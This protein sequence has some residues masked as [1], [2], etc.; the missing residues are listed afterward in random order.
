MRT[1]LLFLFF[2]LLI[3]HVVAGG[4]KCEPITIPLCKNIGYNMTSYP[5]TRGHETQEEAGLEV[6]QFYPLVEVGCYTHLR[7]MLCGLYAP[8]CQEN[9]ELEILP[10]QEVCKEA[11]RKCSP[12]METHGFKWPETLNCDRLPRFADQQTTGTLCAAPPDATRAGAS[13]AVDEDAFRTGGGE[14]EERNRCDCQCA[15][16]FRLISAESAATA[17]F[18]VQNVSNCAYTCDGLLVAPKA[19]DRAFVRQWTLVFA[20]ICFGLSFFTVLTFAIDLKRFPYPERPI[21]Y[22]A[23]CQSMFALGY[24]L[25][26]LVDGE[27][28]GCES[29][30][31][32]QANHPVANSA[33]L[34]CMAVFTLTYYFSMAG[35]AFWVVLTVSFLLA[36]VPH[37]SSEWI[38]R[39]SRWFHLGAW[40][41]PAVQVAL[42]HYFGAV[43]GD[44]LTGICSV[45]NTN[46]NWLLLFVILPLAL[47]F[48]VGLLCLFTGFRNLCGIRADLKKTHP[49]MDKTSKLTQLM[50]KIGLFAAIYAV[51]VVFQLALL[52]VEFFFRPRWERAFL[53]PGC[54]DDRAPD[55]YT[56]FLLSLMRTGA[57]MLSGWA[58]AIWILSPKT[59]QSWRR[60]LCC[61]PN[62]YATYTG[63]R[64]PFGEHLIGAQYQPIP[65]PPQFPPPSVRKPPYPS[66]ILD[67]Y[68]SHE[69]VGSPL[70]YKSGTLRHG[71]FY[72]DNV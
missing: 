15:A 66:P 58:V 23:F 47:Y 54:T 32:R 27:T 46:V 60:R 2:G 57:A 70:T 19:D 7:F 42:A 25:P 1:L 63:A 59:L 62:P 67:V 9:Y 41:I 72:P 11:Q 37:W 45:G 53:C 68:K 26:A 3:A 35:G 31:L 55:N 44:P 17:R 28:V 49:N 69:V 52:L 5:N 16:P 29:G 48:L 6:H 8:I 56:L 51:A 34:G 61:T 13:H 12:L 22:F 20:A 40:G 38:A 33:N 24:L 71:G 50:S 64:L 30:L 43:D 4:K 39:C 36:A 21:L 65:A 10:C 14:E 18:H